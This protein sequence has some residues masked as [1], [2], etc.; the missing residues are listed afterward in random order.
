MPTRPKT[1]D[2]LRLSGTFQNN[3]SRYR[4][5]IEPHKASMT[6]PKLPLGPAPKHLDA[7]GKA[8][9]AELLR[10]APKHSLS[11]SHRL[12]L[13]ILV[14]LIAKLRA[15]TIK[16]GELNTMLTM[17][18]RLGLNPD[19]IGQSP[20]EEPTEKTP[21]QLAEDARWAELDCFD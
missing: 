15:G 11:K 2:E 12:T 16:V 3:P 21:E 6:A 1:L 4:H 20:I 17:L 19:S 14:G 10:S 5:L 8:I 9:W 18:T 13:E 7:P